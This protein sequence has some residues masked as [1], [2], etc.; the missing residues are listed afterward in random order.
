MLNEGYTLYQSLKRCGIIESKSFTTEHPE[1]RN[2]GKKD[3][4]VVGLEENGAVST[5]EFRRRDEINR[6]WTTAK[7]NHNSFPVIKLQR[8]LVKLNLNDLLRNKLKESKTDETGKRK[9]LID[10]DF[11]LNVTQNDINKWNSLHERVS[12]LKPFFETTDSEYIVV[13]ELIKR[14]QLLTKWEDFL[15]GI[16]NQVKL[17][18]NLLSYSFFENIVIGKKFNKIKNE[19]V[20]EIP[21]VLEVS[22]WNNERKFLNRIASNNAKLR[23]FVSTCLF[24]YDSEK[25]KEG[26]QEEKNNSALSGRITSLVPEK[27]PD[28]ILG[29]IGKSF[30]FSANKAI[31]SLSRYG[32][33]STDLIPVGNDE[34]NSIKDSLRWITNSGREFKTWIKVPSG[35]IESRNGKKAYKDDM[36]IIYIENKPDTNINKAYMLGGL[37]KDDFSDTDYES[38]SKVAIDALHGIEIIK[39]SDLIRMFCLRKVDPGRTQVSLQRIYT[40]SNLVKADQSWREAAMNYPNINFPFFKKEIEKSIE[41]PEDISKSIKTFLDDKDS[42]LII[43]KPSC[44]FP[45]DL[46]RLTQRQWIRGGEDFISVAG[47]SLG[48]IYDMFFE[49]E[50]EKRMLIENLLNRTLQCTKILLS[51]VGNTDHQRE[52]KTN[53]KIF[54]KDKRFIVLRTV[55]ALAIYLY[56]L[57][58]KKENYMKDTFFYIGRFLSLIDT[59]HFEYCKNVRGGSIPPQLLGNSHLQIALDNPISALDM[60]SRRLS[61]YQAWTRKEQGEQVKLAR[62]AVGELGKVSDLITNKDLPLTTTSV[63]RAQI[64]LGYLYRPEN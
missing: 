17:S 29:H 51:G 49:S 41:N 44:P 19:F 1:L 31:P 22:D 53:P 57:G 59:L 58:I 9:L 48:D 12:E 63:E 5:I 64:L 34:A 4:L 33:R 24:N 11:E 45:A 56:K 6:L 16:L 2:P 23:S 47:C 43:L 20:I 30:I 7:G 54:F 61:V 3:G 52:L 62:W 13:H 39:A 18:N 50:N 38:I 42:K 25:I 46:V 10:Q 15:A 35:M 60:V 26:K 40:I 21:L 14:F 37:S 36:L 32:R 55:S 28:P 8:P 27:F